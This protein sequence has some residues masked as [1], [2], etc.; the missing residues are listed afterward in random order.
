MD[1]LQFRCYL[2]D[3]TVPRPERPI[4]IFSTSQQ[5]AE[6]WARKVLLSAGEG[7][8]VWMYKLEETLIGSYKK[9]V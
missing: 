9:K 4:Q 3:P 6:D 2:F 1:T 7:S 5:T 8:E